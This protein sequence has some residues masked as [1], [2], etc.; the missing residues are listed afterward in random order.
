MKDDGS[1]VA[2]GGELVN[3]ERLGRRLHAM[4]KV[5]RAAATGD[6]NTK[7]MT[8]S[9]TQYCYVVAVWNKQIIVVKRRPFDMRSA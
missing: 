6:E 3:N 2:T 7:R 8:I 4:I 1:I 9:F 5:A